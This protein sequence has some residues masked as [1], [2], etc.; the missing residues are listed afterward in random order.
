MGVIGAV[1]RRHFA[2]LGGVVEDD[3]DHPGNRIGA[4]LRT[5]A[6]AQ[7]FD[8]FDRADR[9]RVEI[10]RR[11]A[12]TDLRG[13]VDHRRSVP[14]FTVDQHQHL[15]RAHAAQLSGAYM[16]GTAGVGLA[17]QAE[18]W[19]QRLQRCAQFAIR[20][21]GGFQVISGEHVDRHW[22][23]QH[24]AR[25]AACA[26]DQYGIEFGFIVSLRGKLPDGREHSSSE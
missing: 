9:D 21:A 11:R 25:C 13:I 22:R 6:V 8:A 7:H 3:V 19:Q 5:G 4:V 15:I 18:R 24:G 20:R 26:G 17:R 12:A 23:I 1:A 10:H 2:A 14:A 16:V